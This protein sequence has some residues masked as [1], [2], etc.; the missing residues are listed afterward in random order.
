MAYSS[1]MSS[2]PSTTIS[3]VCVYN[4]LAVRQECLDRTVHKYINSRDSDTVIEYIPVNNIHGTYPS[5]GSALNYGASIAKND[6]IVFV[7]Q[8][9]L[10]HSVEAVIEAADHMEQ[11]NFGVLGAIGVQSRGRIVGSIRDRSVLLGDPVTQPTDV[12]SVDELLFMVPRSLIIRE[13]LAESPDLAWHAYAVEYG[14]RVRRRGLRVGVA[15]IPVTHNS[16]TSNLAR[17]DVAHAAVAAQYRD[18]LPVHTTCG[19]L[20]KRTIKGPRHAWLASQRS[21]YRWLTNS[22]SISEVY[23]HTTTPVIFADVRFAVDEIAGKSPGRK[24]YI[25]NHTR[26]GRFTDGNDEFMELKRRGNVIAATAQEV[27]ELREVLDRRPSGSWLL[28]TNMTSRDVRAV[29]SGFVRENRVIGFHPSIGCW[30]ILGA[31]LSDLPTGW[32]KGPLLLRRN[33]RYP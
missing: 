11:E 7:H 22:L 14:L 8:D 25:L 16:L 26:G 29:D 27:N 13:P 2:R 32:Y 21:R 17:L 12:D 15:H 6:I 3:I 5:A 31:E 20:A 18:M 28:I 10:L 4:D 9:V 19:I 1:R 33:I 24:L 30:M 23:R